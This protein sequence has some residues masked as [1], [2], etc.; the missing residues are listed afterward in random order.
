MMNEINNE[1]VRPH[2]LHVHTQI[3][4][5]GV[6]RSQGTRTRFPSQGVKMTR[7]PSSRNNL[8]ENPNRRADYLADMERKKRVIFARI[9]IVLD[10]STWRTAKP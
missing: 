10:S 3:Q 7:A 4:R 1:L 8:A 6:A 9:Q 2:L 5:P